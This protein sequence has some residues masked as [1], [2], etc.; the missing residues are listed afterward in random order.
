MTIDEVFEVLYR[1]LAYADK[2]NSSEYWLG[3]SDAVYMAI[4]RVRQLTS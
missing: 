4:S 3:Y 1:E 2:N